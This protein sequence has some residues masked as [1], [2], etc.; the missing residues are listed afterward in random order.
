VSLELSHEQF[1][2]YS[3]HLLMDDIGEAGQLKLSQARVLI[4]G[5]GG[6]GCPVALYLAAAGVGQLSLC[7]P[8]CVELSNLQR[9][10]LYRETDCD[11]Y[12][13]ECADTNMRI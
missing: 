11:R 12:K 10:I 8:D 7:D 2:R 9:Q 1:M 4:V 3:R 6:L 13:V 5:L